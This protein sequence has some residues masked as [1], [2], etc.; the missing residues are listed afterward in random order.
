VHT[1]SKLSAHLQSAPK[2]RHSSTR[3]KGPDPLSVNKSQ[4]PAKP[5]V[6]AIPSSMPSSMPHIQPARTR[7]TTLVAVAAESNP[8]E[9]PPLASPTTVK[10]TSHKAPNRALSPPFVSPRRILATSLAS[11]SHPPT[12]RLAT[13]AD[14]IAAQRAELAQQ[15]LKIQQRA[16][17]ASVSASSRANVLAGQLR[18]WDI[19]SILPSTTSA[20]L[21]SVSTSTPPSP[22]NAATNVITCPNASHPT[23][24]RGF[25]ARAGQTPVVKAHAACAQVVQRPLEA[26]PGSSAHKRRCSPAP[27]RAHCTVSRSPMPIR[28][29]KATCTGNGSSTERAPNEAD[30]APV[31]DGSLL[32]GNKAFVESQ[33]SLQVFILLHQAHCCS[34]W[35]STCRCLLHS[36]TCAGRSPTSLADD[37]MQASQQALDDCLQHCFQ[38]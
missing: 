19:S 1:S 2:T 29:R 16:A 38:T 26:L 37:N 30:P 21:K 10:G 36:T 23:Q 4:A 15:Q 3:I 34:I 11:S 35:K 13:K 22:H 7:G 5:A 18:S 6:A 24:S 32:S 12:P 31:T 27:C 9:T 28:S 33:L 14:R 8:R 25:S 20:K 17:L